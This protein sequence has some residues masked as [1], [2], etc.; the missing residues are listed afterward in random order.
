MKRRIRNGWDRN[1]ITLMLFAGSFG[2]PLVAHAL[3]RLLA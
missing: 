3:A 2:A 1:G